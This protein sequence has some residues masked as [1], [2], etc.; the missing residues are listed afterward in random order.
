[1]QAQV[2]S[3]KCLLK[4]A[5]GQLISS[6]FNRDVLTSASGDGAPLKGLAQALHGLEKGESRSIHLKA[7]DAYGFYD[8]NKVILFPLRK[9]P[10][11]P[12]VRCGQTVSILSKTQKLRTYRILQ[13]HGDMV[14]LDENHPLAGQDLI[15]EIEAT[16]ARNATPEELA[17]SQDVISRRWVH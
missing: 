3:F 2:V 8:P 12:H 10:N 7:E 9:I 5:A 6:S 17:E 15:F 1:M 11:F 14:S 16:E 4:N 13:I